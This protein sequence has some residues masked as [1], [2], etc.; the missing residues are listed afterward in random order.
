[1][2]LSLIFRNGHRLRF[3]KAKTITK[4]IKYTEI[5]IYFIIQFLYQGL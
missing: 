4:I 5:Y 1:M 3:F 2:T